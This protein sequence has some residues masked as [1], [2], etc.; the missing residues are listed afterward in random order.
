MSHT[1]NGPLSWRPLTPFGVEV[2]RDLASP[3]SAAEESHLVQLL[4]THGFVLARNQTLSM[5][6]QREICALAGP[7]LLREG[8]SGIMSNEGGETSASELSWHADAAYTDAPF[9]AL[10]LHALD[11]VANTSSTRFVNVADALANLP[12]AL[13]QQLENAQV[14][15][16]SPGYDALGGRTCN[17]RDPA[18]QKRGVLPAIYR[19]PHNDRDGI[20][21][22]ELQAVRVLDMAWEESRDLLNAV[23][24]HLYQEANVLEHFWRNGDLIIWDNI[25]LQHMRGSLRECGRRV[26]QRVI[27]GTQGV[28]PHIEQAA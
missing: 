18:A 12:D 6:R 7:I 1:Q 14:E 16:I 11:V 4:W 15:M 8:E 27:V 10:S 17:Q 2:L 5:E 28:A 20:W 25:G 19:N 21:V 26:L 13:R 23:Y 9:D 24:D 22:S 3:L